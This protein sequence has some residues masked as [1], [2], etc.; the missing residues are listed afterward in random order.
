MKGR[1]RKM[2]EKAGRPDCTG[3]C[4]PC[5]FCFVL[6]VRGSIEEFDQICI[7]NPSL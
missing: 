5:E 6:R 4:K 2:L 3:L 7:L 1:R